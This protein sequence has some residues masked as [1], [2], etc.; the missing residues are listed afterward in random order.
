MRVKIKLKVT[1]QAQVHSTPS[2]EHATMHSLNSNTHSSLTLSR[3]LSSRTKKPWAPAAPRSSVAG[4][5]EV[6]VHSGSAGHQVD[7]LFERY[8]INSLSRT[9]RCYPGTRKSLDQ[10]SRAR[11]TAHIDFFM[12]LGLS[13][14]DISNVLLRYPKVSR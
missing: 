6:R 14:Q 1:P 8:S 4:N 3:L 10:G 2:S 7:D 5:R 12:T 13:P 11:L 9:D